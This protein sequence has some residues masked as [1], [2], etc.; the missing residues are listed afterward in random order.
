MET[1]TSDLILTELREF[2]AAVTTWQQE[3]GERVAAVETSLKPVLGNGQPG[4]LAVVE[5]RLGELEKT[6]WKQAGAYAALATVAV[7]GWE[8]VKKYLLGL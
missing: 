2:R 8:L 4:R 5:S 1:S 3:T 7:A 6:Q